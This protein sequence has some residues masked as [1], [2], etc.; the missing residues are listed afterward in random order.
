VG[1]FANNAFNGE[2][3]KTY[4]NGKIEDG[5]WKDWVFTGKPRAASGHGG[6]NL[7]KLSLDGK[8]QVFF[9]M[10]FNSGGPRKTE[11]RMLLEAVEKRGVSCY[12]ASPTTGDDIDDLVVT[13]LDNAQVFVAF[14][15]K[16]YAEKTGNTASTYKEVSYWQ[17]TRAKKL[18]ADNIVPINM[19]REGEEFLHPKA[20][21][22]FGSNVAYQVWQRGTPVPANLV[23]EIVALAK[24][25]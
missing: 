25:S 5:I 10:R 19:L 17:N 4:A 24:K 21:M 16:D 23:D 22:L 14:G 1:Q 20:Q 3:K 8:K 15:T 18:G 6:P 2:G 13:A 7:G 12:V 9:S 11:A